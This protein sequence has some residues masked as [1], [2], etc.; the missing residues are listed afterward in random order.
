MSLLYSIS[1]SDGYAALLHV[2][3]IEE[4]EDTNNSL[5]SILQLLVTH[6]FLFFM[7]CVVS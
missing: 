2:I 4:S 5:T 3:F 6:R 1:S 7:F